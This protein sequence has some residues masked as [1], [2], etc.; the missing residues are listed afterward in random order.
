MNQAESE[1]AEQR[2]K[3]IMGN[4]LRT[5]VIT[6]AVIVF[7]GGVLYLIRY[8]H[9][10]PDYEIF[11][12]QP[13]ELRHPGTIISNA[14]S[15]RRRALIEMGLLVLIATPAIQIIFAAFNFL[16]QR[17]YIYSG[18]CLIVL[19]LLFYSLTLS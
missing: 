15:F 19:I 17:D 12:G 8:G 3:N 1:S 13:E 6:A 9:I 10:L 7:A 14:L 11:K 16:R 4:V 2:M 18:I 5:G